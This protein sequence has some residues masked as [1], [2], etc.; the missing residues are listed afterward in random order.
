MVNAVMETSA[1]GHVV[2][3]LLFTATLGAIMSTADSLLIAISHLTAVEIVQPFLPTATAAQLSAIGKA[4]SVLSL[5]V[6]VGIS[7]AMS[8]RALGYVAR[9]QFGLSWQA[10]VSPRAALTPIRPPTPLPPPHQAVP[11]FVL[12]LFA[13][14]PPHPWLLALSA[15]VG[16]CVC[17]AIEVHNNSSAGTDHLVDSAM[18]SLGANLVC[19]LLGAV[20]LR[21]R[22]PVAVQRADADDRPLADG[23]AT[24]WPEGRPPPAWDLPPPSKLRAFGAAPLTPSLMGTL[25]TDGVREPATTFWFAPAWLVCSAIGLPYASAGSPPLDATT[26]KLAYEPVRWAG[27]PVWVVRM[28]GGMVGFTIVHMC[29]I[30]LWVDTSEGPPKPERRDARPANST[31]TDELSLSVS[32]GATKGGVETEAGRRQ[33]GTMVAPTSRRRNGASQSDEVMPRALAGE[34]ELAP[35]TI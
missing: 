13:R 5:G 18:P 29:A 1:F 24:T 34:V 30:W 33:K 2:G 16:I 10:R 17:L 31:A 35:S 19:I 12:G 27:L 11:A 9:A 8:D 3:V 4:S 7:F 32:D 6:A 22:R 25:C 15:C 21:T 14:A 28:L 20:T 23:V 26:G